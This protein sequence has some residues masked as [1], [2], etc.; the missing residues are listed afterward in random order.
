MRNNWPF[1]INIDSK[2]NLWVGSTYGAVCY[3]LNTG[4]YRVYNT[5]SE[6]TSKIS[7]NFVGQIYE[8]SDHRIWLGTSYG[9][10]VIFKDQTTRIISTSDGLSSNQIRS[11]IEDGKGDIWIGTINGLNKITEV[12]GDKLTVETYNIEDGL[13]NNCF[14][15]NS[16][17]KSNDGH[18]F[19]GGIDGFT[20]FHPDSIEYNREPPRVVFTEFRLFNQKVGVINPG[21]SMKTADNQFRLEKSIQY[22]DKIKLNEKQNLISFSFASLNYINPSN[23]QYAYTLEGF[24]QDWIYSGN[25]NSAEYSNLTPGNYT[26]LVKATNNDGIWSKEDLSI[27]IEVIPSFWKSRFASILYIVLLISI[28]FLIIY[29]VRER[30]VTKLQSKQKEL[31][32]NHKTQ[33]FI[34]VAH[35]IKTPLTLISLPLRKLLEQNQNSNSIT[36]KTGELKTVYRN[37]LRLLRIA[38]QILDFRK[39]ELNKV[40]F[41]VARYDIVPFIHSIIQYFEYQAVENKVNIQFNYDRDKDL[42]FYFDPDKMDKILY[43]ILSN[44][45]RYSPEH[46]TILINI[47]SIYKKGQPARGEI[48]YIKIEIEDEGPGISADRLNTIYERFGSNESES[49]RLREGSGI[50]LS[51]A[52]EFTELHN[53]SIQVISPCKTNAPDTQPGTKVILMFPS[54][55]MFLQNEQI[56]NS[57]QRHEEIIL[58]NQ[59]TIVDQ[60]AE[61]EA[62]EEFEPQDILHSQAYRILLIE[63][64]PELRGLMRNDFGICH[65]LIEARDGESGLRK[66]KDIIPDLIISD[67][68]LPGI[69]G[70]DLL[71]ALKQAVETS[72]I[73]IILLTAKTTQNDEIEAYAKGADAFVRKPFNLKTLKHLAES[74][75]ENRLKLKQQFLS[76][77]G[78]ELRNAVPTNTDE[79]FIERLIKLTNDHISD[80]K[81]GVTL[82]TRELGMSRAQLYKKVNAITN[83]SV[84]LFIRKI[85][86]NKAA[87]LLKEENLTITEISY[88]V[89]FDSLPYFSKCFHEEF[90]VSPSKYAESIKSPK[91]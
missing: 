71:T 25:R 70:Y 34:N 52:K 65:E 36:V 63:D 74:L 79:K 16:A 53:G 66:A 28:I 78:I 14:L 62:D 57:I 87:Q 47:S 19:F 2:D 69:S 29:A 81:L 51:I 82:F 83:T 59:L 68:M 24:D 35:E 67:V 80:P 85:R 13:H 76:S 86:L 15:N 26:L 50:G 43:N 21:Q 44:A 38:M 31:L 91:S 55:D 64:D 84:K 48:P 8:D 58:E 49:S 60:Y 11:I 32:I 18:L 17:F 46:A 3:D 7:N 37:V 6:I 90:G 39:I 42:S 40:Q 77:Y 20:V 72:H 12:T 10:N 1:S 73:P 88:T 27:A 41:E 9:L 89:G 75:I 56:T 4:I 23:N 30:E 5:E 45:M 54:D 33:F 22:L 61:E